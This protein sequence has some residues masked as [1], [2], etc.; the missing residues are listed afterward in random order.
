M[1]VLI[2]NVKLDCILKKH[3]I[4]LIVIFDSV[5]RRP[6]RYV[7][8]VIYIFIIGLRKMLSKNVALAFK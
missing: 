3:V 7:K 4:L 6:Y 8:L 2:I 1:M 5:F